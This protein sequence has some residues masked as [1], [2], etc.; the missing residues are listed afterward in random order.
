VKKDSYLKFLHKQPIEDIN[1]MLDDKLVDYISA[2][3]SP[4]EEENETQQDLEY[5]GYMKYFRDCMIKSV[6]TKESAIQF[7]LYWDEF[8][9]SCDEQ[10][11]RQFLSNV[12]NSIIKHYKMSYLSSLLQENEYSDDDI[13]DFINFIVYNNWLEYFP[14]CLD[15]IDEKILTNDSMVKIFLTSDYD[16]FISKLDKYKRCNILIR[17][18]FKYCSKDDGVETL[19]LILKDDMLSNFI[20]QFNLKNKQK[21]SNNVQ[22][23]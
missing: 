23:H 6:G 4:F 11:F 19:R 3:K 15:Y 21:E 1:K 8:K 9:S 5:D 18:Y 2:I 10:Q 17:E 14:R 22:D 20:E 13:I 16:N 7:D 12:L